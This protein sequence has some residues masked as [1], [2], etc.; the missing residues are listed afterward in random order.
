MVFFLSLSV[1]VCLSVLR[2]RDFCCIVATVERRYRLAQKVLEHQETLLRS[3]NYR[4]RRGGL[5]EKVLELKPG[6]QAVV[7]ICSPAEGLGKWSLHAYYSTVTLEIAPKK[8][9]W[10]C[11]FG[12][13]N[14]GWEF[15]PTGGYS[16]PFFF[17]GFIALSQGLTHST[18][19][20]RNLT[21]WAVALIETTCN[22]PTSVL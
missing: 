16:A 2:L 19:C 22:S 12:N 7:L 1:C 5:D 15:R 11:A 13:G 17:F 6:T 21:V 8:K 10:S 4:R 18:S 9:N 3:A 20:Q 14:S